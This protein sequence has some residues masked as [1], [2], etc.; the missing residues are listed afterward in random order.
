M[1][2]ESFS[3]IT[4]YDDGIFFFLNTKIVTRLIDILINTENKYF[5]E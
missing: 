4:Q 1:L 3:V 5:D 2:L